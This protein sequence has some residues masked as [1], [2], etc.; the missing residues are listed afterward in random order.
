MSGDHALV[1][2][3]IDLGPAAFAE[4]AL[5]ATPTAQQWEASKAL[6]ERRRVS[7]RSGHGTGKSAFQAWAAMW[8]MSTRPN[9]KIPITAPTS[10]QLK[11]VLL[12]LIHI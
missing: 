7:I 8:F 3:W 2:H 11:D 4:D 9:V 6:V 12:S 10:H 1:N 5:G